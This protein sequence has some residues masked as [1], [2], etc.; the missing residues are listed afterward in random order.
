[1]A[2]ALQLALEGRQFRVNALLAL[3][4]L[5]LGIESFPP[6]VEVVGRNAEL[7]GDHTSRLAAVDPTVDRF[8]LEGS[9][10]SAVCSARFGLGNLRLFS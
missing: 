2:H 8:L 5:R 6:I 7:L 9:I 3:G 1:M 4:R 10:K